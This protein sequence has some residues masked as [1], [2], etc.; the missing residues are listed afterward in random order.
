[1]YQIKSV[2][3][4]LLTQQPKSRLLPI[5]SPDFTLNGQ[6]WLF[7]AEKCIFLKKLGALLNYSY[8]QIHLIMPD[9]KVHMYYLFFPYCL[10]IIFSR[11]C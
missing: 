5:F 10:I 2:E 7:Y 11:Y 8:Y 1:M 6:I 3:D 9:N 4:K